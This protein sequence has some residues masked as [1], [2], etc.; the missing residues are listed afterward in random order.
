VL[1]PELLLAGEA[2]TMLDGSGCAGNLQMQDE[3]RRGGLGILMITHDLSTAA[4]FADR[5]AVMYLGRIVEEGP[6]REVVTN[7]KHPYTKAL[8]SV[9]PQR[10][11]RASIE[12]QILRGETPN[13]IAVPPGCRFNPRC[14]I[15]IA[16]CRTVDP[17]LRVPSGA[18]AGHLAACI[19]A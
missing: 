3:L 2:V 17:E 11:P 19:R 12:P 6:A 1:E 15:A 8:I 14:P 7:P 18:P 16:E 13:P 5:I 9:V 10:D 4:H